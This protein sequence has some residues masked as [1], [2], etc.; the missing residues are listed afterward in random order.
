MTISNRVRT[1][2][3]P[4]LLTAGLAASTITGCHTRDVATQDP[5]STRIELSDIIHE[6]AQVISTGSNSKQLSLHIPFT[7][8]G[9]DIKYQPPTEY[10]VVFHGAVDFMVD[11]EALYRRFPAGSKADVSYQK[12]F[13]ISYED[14]MQVKTGKTFIGYVFVGAQSPQGSP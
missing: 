8:K 14:A 7:G 9:E 6:D 5:D 2:V 4:Y 12:A 1:T 13:R 11:N 3:A 10:R